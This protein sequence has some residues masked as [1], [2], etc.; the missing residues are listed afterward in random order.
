MLCMYIKYE[1]LKSGY[2]ETL[3]STLLFFCVSENSE[4]ELGKCF[5]YGFPLYL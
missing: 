4:K 1:T 2:T 5:R 3:V